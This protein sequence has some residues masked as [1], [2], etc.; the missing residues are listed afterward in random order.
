MTSRKGALIMSN[1]IYV[2]GMNVS[3]ELFNAAERLTRYLKN[4]KDIFSNEKKLSALINQLDIF[5]ISFTA[6]NIDRLMSTIICQFNESY[7]QQSQ[8]YVAVTEDGVI[9]SAFRG[10]KNILGEEIY[11]D[12]ED[13]IRTT[14]IPFYQKVTEVEDGSKR[15]GRDKDKYVYGIPIEDARYVL[16]L[17]VNT[18]VDMTIAFPQLFEIYRLGLKEYHNFNYENGFYALMQQ[19]SK[20]LPPTINDLCNEL[21]YSN[22]SAFNISIFS[23]N[24][25]SE[26]YKDLDDL[27]LEALFSQE[28]LKNKE[29]NIT[30]SEDFNT[31]SGLNSMCAAAYTSTKACSKM[32]DVK[33]MNNDSKQK[34][35][36]RVTG[37][38][39]TSIEEHH[40]GLIRYKMSLSCYHQFLRHRIPSNRVNWSLFNKYDSIHNAVYIPDSIKNS[41]FYTE[42]VEIMAKYRDYYTFAITRL[43]NVFKQTHHDAAFIANRLAPNAAMIE[44]YSRSNLRADK[45]I[46]RERLCMTAASE[47]RHLMANKY[48]QITKYDAFY[49]NAVPPCFLGQK[50]KEGMM[51]CKYLPDIVKAKNDGMSV[52]DLVRKFS[53]ND[54]KDEDK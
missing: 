32:T 2:D 51:H 5:Y 36:D 41:E 44:V 4:N 48:L 35:I 12:M 28:T 15:G 34:V 19:I 26:Y 7:T 43:T 23:E 54:G 39:H 31:N 30:I 52:S 47:I 50:C 11:C 14:V 20:E 53:L 33:A 6:H 9:N 40:Q 17:F 13:F 18:T 45:W 1:E 16:P 25:D 42:Y 10:M 8:R 3:Q 37:Y 22:D 27:F 38:G 46:N 24:T 49:E 21:L 29:N